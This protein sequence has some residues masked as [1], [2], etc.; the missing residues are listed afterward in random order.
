M[1][2]VAASSA[3]VDGSPGDVVAADIDNNRRPKLLVAFY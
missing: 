2:S 3:F 1:R